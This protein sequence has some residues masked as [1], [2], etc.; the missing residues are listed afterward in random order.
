MILSKN[1]TDKDPKNA[2]M[3]PEQNI[4]LVNVMEILPNRSQPRKNFENNGIARL[5]DSIRRFGILHPLTVRRINY[6]GFVP[7]GSLPYR[8]ELISGERRLR[9]AMLLGLERVPCI[10]RFA[11]EREAAELAVI[12]NLLRRDLN[13]FEQARAFSKLIT[14]FSMTQ[15]EVAERLSSA[16]SS[17]ANKLRLLKLSDGEQ[18][19]ILDH[20]LTERHARALLKIGDES[21]RTAV[22]REIAERKLNVSTSEEYIERVLAAN[23]LPTAQKNR[24]TS[25]Q[26]PQDPPPDAPEAPAFD[27]KT[28]ERSIFKLLQRGGYKSSIQSL[29]TE[30]GETTVTLTVVLNKCFT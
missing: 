17:V 13:M 4:V 14:E 24:D 2:E 23:L 10:V 12:E 9:A 5:A 19:Y 21:L 3:L 18:Q 22:L 8:Y 30:E 6:D 28:L 20:D 7:A 27:S 29:S 26:K 25:P 11:S 1:R 16:Q 15:Q